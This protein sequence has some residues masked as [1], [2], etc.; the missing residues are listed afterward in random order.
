MAEGGVGGED[1]VVVEGCGQGLLFFNTAHFH[2]QVLGSAA[3]DDA[4]GGEDFLQLGAYLLGKA[5]LHLQPPGEHVDYAGYFA[6][7]DD[8]A[9]GDVT[10][11]DT[12][13][14]WKYMVLAE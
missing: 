12:A 2:A 6:Q 8:F 14:E 1:A 11:G 10:Y 5:F 4:F 9:V 3:G 13:E 7:P